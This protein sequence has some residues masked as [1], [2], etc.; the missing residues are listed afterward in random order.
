M[1][2]TI[3]LTLIC[4]L[5]IV[6][7]STSIMAQSNNNKVVMKKS[8]SYLTEAENFNKFNNFNLAEVSQNDLNKAD[9]P[10]LQ[11]HKQSLELK[12]ETVIDQPLKHQ[13]LTAQLNKLTLA[14]DSK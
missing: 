2:K 6:L 5:S 3:L 13:A 11:K 10:T 1:K 7:F 9:L 12:I 4:F 8:F 14:I